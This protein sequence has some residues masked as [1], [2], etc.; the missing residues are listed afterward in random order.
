MPRNIGDG[1]LFDL[2]RQGGMGAADAREC[3]SEGRK[4][5]FWAGDAWHGFD[6]PAGPEQ[7]NPAAMPPQKLN[8]PAGYTQSALRLTDAG[9]ARRRHAG[10]SSLAMLSATAGVAFCFA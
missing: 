6:L 9:L 8:T 1:D 4:S 3:Q 5:A 7:V 10:E 2:L